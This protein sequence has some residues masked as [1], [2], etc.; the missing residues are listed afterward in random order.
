MCKTIKIHQA[1]AVSNVIP[2]SEY[3]RLLRCLE[4]DKNWK[5]LYGV[6]LLAMTGARVSEY[7]RLQKKDFDRGYA[8]MWT[9]GK[10]R[11][12][13][14]PKQFRDEAAAYYANADLWDRIQKREPNAYLVLLYWD[15]EMFRRST[16]KRRD[17]EA[18]TEKKDYKALCKD[19]L[20]LHPEKYTIAKD[21]KAHLDMWRGMFIKTYGIA[22]DK[23]YKTM[24]EGLLYGDPKMRVLRIL[25]TEIYNDHNMMI[26]EAQRGKQQH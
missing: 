13:Y 4:Q 16:K 5:W 14:I 2:V 23:H 21:T 11:R 22:M 15:S 1:T 26:K 3:E 8:E 20:F 10:I 6:K 17:L 12:I 19:I 25:W 24:Y 7:I 18:G 9:K